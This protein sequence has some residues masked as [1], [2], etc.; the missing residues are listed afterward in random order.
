MSDDRNPHA[1]CGTLYPHRRTF[2][3]DGHL[4]GALKAARAFATELHLREAPIG[5]DPTDPRRRSP[6]GIILPGDGDDDPTIRPVGHPGRWMRTV[7]L[8][9]RDPPRRIHA[10]R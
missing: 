5:D 3:D 4:A 1:V 8:Y 10:E 2:P 9:W 6:D 7:T